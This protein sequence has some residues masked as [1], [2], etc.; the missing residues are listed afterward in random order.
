MPHLWG[1]HLYQSNVRGTNILH[2]CGTASLR[3]PQL[4]VLCAD[5]LFCHSSLIP[6]TS[7]L[8]YKAFDLLEYTLLHWCVLLVDGAHLG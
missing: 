3:S 6:Y 4:I 8:L 5:I 7:E 1:D 2:S